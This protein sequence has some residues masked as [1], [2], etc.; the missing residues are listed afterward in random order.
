MD[1]CRREISRLGRLLRDLNTEGG[2]ETGRA[3]VML[4][5]TIQA[6]AG[7]NSKDSPVSLEVIN[8]DTG[9]TSGG[10]LRHEVGHVL[11]QPRRGFHW[12][13]PRREAEL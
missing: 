3:E 9:A 8:E 5:V 12:L 2:P 11:G 6:P 10:I 7:S 1:T 4:R 13:H